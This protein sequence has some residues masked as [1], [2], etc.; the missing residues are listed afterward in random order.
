MI[1]KIK[2][3][4]EIYL[5]ELKKSLSSFDDSLSLEKKSD[6]LEETFRDP[7]VLIESIQAIQRKQ[8]ESMKDIQLKLNQMAKIKSDL[9]ATNKFKP[10]LS[11]FNQEGDTSL[12]GSIYLDVY[13]NRNSLKSSQIL[14][15]NQPNELIRLCEFSPNDKWTL[16]YRATRDGFD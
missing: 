11:P 8:E 13:S 9:K 3:H 15:G 7:N 14:T 5:K 4:E 12:F 6:E 16:L 1:D 10:N 2:K